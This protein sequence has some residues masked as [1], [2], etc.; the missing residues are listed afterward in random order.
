MARAKFKLEK[1]EAKKKK[2]EE[3]ARLAKIKEELKKKSMENK[4]NRCK[5]MKLPIRL[6]SPAFRFARHSNTAFKVPAN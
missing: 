3:R 5:R 6:I 1:E 4:E 2:A